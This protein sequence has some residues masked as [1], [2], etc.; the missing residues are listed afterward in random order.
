M[1]K[2]YIAIPLVIIFTIAAFTFSSFAAPDSVYDIPFTFTV[3]YTYN[4]IRKSLFLD[5]F[6]SG[7][8]HYSYI[9]FLEPVS[10]EVFTQTFNF[11]IGEG[12]LL[13]FYVVLRDL[14][15]DA[16]LY[17]FSDNL[18][19]YRDA[20]KDITGNN[21]FGV[22]TSYNIDP[23]SNTF[24]LSTNSEPG[25]KTLNYFYFEDVPSGSYFIQDL[26]EAI[27]VVFG[28]YVTDVIAPSPEPDPEPVPPSAFLSDLGI[29]VS[30]GLSWVSQSVD[31]IV[32]HPFLLLTVGLFCL[33]AAI[34]FLGRL[35]SRE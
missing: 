7:S 30:S 24:T 25:T 27:S 26:R 11:D 18:L 12:Y 16:G 2:R 22:V 15:V 33:G 29:V 21:I 5:T 3:D 20:S 34:S 35:L 8:D 19:Q 14:T 6:K 10:G 17:S 13:D 31:T 1:V 28:L 32:D 23:V 4:G 9:N